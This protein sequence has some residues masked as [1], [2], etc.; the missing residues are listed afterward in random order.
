SINTQT[1]IIMAACPAADDIYDVYT[2]FFTKF[3]YKKFKLPVVLAKGIGPT[4]IPRPVQ[5]V[6]HLSE[7]LI[8]PTLD[9]DDPKFDEVLADYHGKL[10]KGMNRLMDE[11]RQYA[12]DI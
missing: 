8:P 11:T 7:P 3:M 4:L 5:L 6:H 12:S 9:R 2:S 1:P 10:V